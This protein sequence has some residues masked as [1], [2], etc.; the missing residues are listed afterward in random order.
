[1]VHKTAL[2]KKKNRCRNKTFDGSD[3]DICGMRVFFGR[4]LTGEKEYPR[5]GTIRAEGNGSKENNN[6]G[7]EMKKKNRSEGGEEVVI[8]RQNGCESRPR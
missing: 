6:R 8:G 1:V 2:V 4:D 7:E 5:R 3:F